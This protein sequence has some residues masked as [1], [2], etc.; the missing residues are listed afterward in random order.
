MLKIVVATKWE[1]QRITK[2]GLI[3]IAKVLKTY[4]YYCNEEQFKSTVSNP[5]YPNYLQIKQ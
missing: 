1:D 4:F 3:G 2:T 5:K